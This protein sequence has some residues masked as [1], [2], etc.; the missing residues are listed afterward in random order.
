MNMPCD[1]YKIKNST[2]AYYEKVIQCFLNK[3]NSRFVVWPHF[4]KHILIIR[5]VWDKYFYFPVWLSWTCFYER[6]DWGEDR[7]YFVNMFEVVFHSRIEESS[8]SVSEKLLLNFCG[9][10]DVF[11]PHFCPCGRQLLP[12][13][14]LLLYV[15]V[16]FSWRCSCGY[17]KSPVTCGFCSLSQNPKWQKFPTCCTRKCQHVQCGS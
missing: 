13:C 5:N 17:R 16:D 11:L 10:S 15:T 7:E 6:L 3:Y 9:I 2:R 8:A 4:S 1:N 14:S 12:W